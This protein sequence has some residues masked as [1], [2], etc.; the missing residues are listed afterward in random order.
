MI[1]YF[2]ELYD[3]ELAYS[4]FARYF[5]HMYPA[6]TSALEDLLEERTL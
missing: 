2:S 6:Y 1:A 5:A 3:D 4:W